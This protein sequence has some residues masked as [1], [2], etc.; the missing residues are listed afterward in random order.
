MFFKS[1]ISQ[2]PLIGKFQKKAKMKVNYPTN[3]KNS[4]TDFSDNFHNIENFVQ[5]DR[6]FKISKNRFIF[7]FLRRRKILGVRKIFPSG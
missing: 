1:P 3:M 4:H 7:P 6:R 5:V 2:D